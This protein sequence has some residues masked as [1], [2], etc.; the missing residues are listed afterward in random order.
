MRLCKDC[1]TRY[2]GCHSECSY[3]VVNKVINTYKKNKEKRFNY[4][5]CV[6]KEETMKLRRELNG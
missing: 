4:N 6:V 3:Y 1:D 5:Y 2:I